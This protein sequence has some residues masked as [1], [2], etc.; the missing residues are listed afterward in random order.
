MTTIDTIKTFCNG[1]L[2]AMTFGMYHQYTSNNIMTLNNEMMKISHKADMDAMKQLHNNDMEKLKQSHIN[3]M[4]KLKQ[5]V[6]SI[7][8][9]WW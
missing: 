5:D 3:D 1:A 9:K 2:G 4:E 7:R 6:N 8:R